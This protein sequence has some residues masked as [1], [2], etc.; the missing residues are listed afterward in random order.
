MTKKILWTVTVLLAVAFL[1]V[2]MAFP[3][4]VYRL[5]M[6]LERA[7]AGLHLKS[8]TVDGR[9]IRYLEGGEGE[10][11]L[12]V[13][14]FGADK[15]TWT[16]MARH[17]TQQYHVIAPDLPGFGESS[18]DPEASYDILSQ[19]ENLDRFTRAVGLDPFH[20]AGNS[21]G[22]SISGQYAARYPDKVL[23]LALI[24]TAGVIGCPEKSDFARML[25]NGE[26]P[27]LTENEEGYETKLGMVFVDPPWIPGPL[28][29]YL[30]AEDVK[31][32]DL[33]NMIFEQIHDEG[34]SLVPRL[35][36][37]RARTLILWGDSDRLIHVSCTRV[38]EQGLADSS[39]VIMDAC[40]HAPMLERPEE[41]ADHY[42]AFL[43]Q[44]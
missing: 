20:L 36:D 12:L 17:L 37:I 14:G 13:H 6:S 35:P 39:T 9:E 32:R 28:K 4:S 10:T 16:R 3:G 7:R 25:E 11:V 38:L 27:L 43:Q 21:M 22:G 23:S 42:L 26:N 30:A 34:S 33:L 24:N 29:R 40:G 2:P 8:V 1:L 18:K 31:N 44:G 15:D 5:A 41:T 19:A